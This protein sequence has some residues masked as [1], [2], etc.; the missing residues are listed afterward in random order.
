MLKS[1]QKTEGANGMDNFLRKET[2]I[3][4][5]EQEKLNV[6]ITEN[7]K[8]QIV[9]S[10][11]C[12]LLKSQVFAQDIPWDDAVEQALKNK[13]QLQVKPDLRKMIVQEQLHSKAIKPIL[14]IAGPLPKRNS[15]TFDL[16]F[17]FRLEQSDEQV[18]QDTL[19]LIHKIDAYLEAVQP[20]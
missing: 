2:I 9:V 16:V 4:A 11:M 20:A 6:E 12:E 15:F 13:V 3:T 7:K 5:F 18:L 1:Q 8:G 10:R 19:Q 14:T 17:L